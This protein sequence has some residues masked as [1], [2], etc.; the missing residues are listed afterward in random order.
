MGV[1]PLLG[2]SMMKKLHPS[3]QSLVTEI[4]TFRE[5]NQLNA[6]AFGIQAVNDGKFLADLRQGRIP[7]LT[8]IDRVRAFMCG[9]RSA[10]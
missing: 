3:I 6:T 10:A 2:L 8:T 7:S 1:F 9:E 5:R 4:E